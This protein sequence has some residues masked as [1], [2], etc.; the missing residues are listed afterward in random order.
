MLH[1]VAEN[2]GR[3][4]SP[5]IRNLG[6]VAQLEFGAPQ[7]ISTGF[8]FWQR[9]CTTLYTVS[10]KISHLCIALTLTHMNGF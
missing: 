6:T 2:I 8:V 9:Y 10:Q 7:L 5:K 4:K 3:K 1:A